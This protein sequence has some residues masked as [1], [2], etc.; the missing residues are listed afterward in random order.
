MRPPTRLQ[1]AWH[2]LLRQ[3]R[4]EAGPKPTADGTLFRISDSMSCHRK[5]TLAA[6]GVAPTNEIDGD[7]LSNFEAGTLWHEGYQR[8]AAK[9][10]GAELEVPVSFKPEV[11]LSG[12]AD[13]L[14]WLPTDSYWD[15]YPQRV[16]LEIKTTK[17]KGWYL[18]TLGKFDPTYKKTHGDPGPAVEHIT[19]AALYAI[20]LDADFIHLVYINKNTG[21]SRDTAT[22]WKVDPK[23]ELDCDGEWFFELDEE[24]P[25]LDA[26][27][28]LPW[29]PRLLA[30]A[31]LTAVY[32]LSSWHRDGMVTA[33]EVPWVGNI[34][35]VLKPGETPKDAPK[36]TN[37][38]Y[39]CGTC[40]FNDLCRS[41]PAGPVPLSEVQR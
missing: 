19:Q 21:R 28:G 11:S 33:R 31:E 14:Y 4:E 12:H 29:T 16:V 26:P 20:G 38:F 40:P 5:R 35:Y 37:A 34:D 9:L 39:Q 32:E 25:F 6:H 2:D 30:Q 36:G 41:L 7:S 3:E 8:A 17:E 10:L 1:D 22:N 13:G 18:R 15:E 23:E 24:L 27:P